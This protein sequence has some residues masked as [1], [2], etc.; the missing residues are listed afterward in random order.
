MALT[1]Q[2]EQAATSPNSVAITAGA[3]T[4]KTYMLARR[5]L[6]HLQAQN[7]SP[8]QI[9][10]MTFTDKG[11]V[12]ATEK[13]WSLR[14]SVLPKVIETVRGQLRVAHGVLNVLMSEI[15]LNGAGIMPVINK[16]VTTTMAQHVRM[17]RES[18]E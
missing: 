1:P 4:G 12:L 11:L 9:V 18:E 17:N 2:Q 7:L 15:V 5:Y 8:L 14:N 10:A 6:F 16:L 3:G 13:F